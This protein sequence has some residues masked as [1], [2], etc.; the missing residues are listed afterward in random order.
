[1]STSPFRI[2]V[3]ICTMLLLSASSF[4]ADQ[5]SA[6]KPTETA[7]FAN[8]IH[9]RC[10]T[11]VNGRF[12]YFAI[13]TAEP[14]HTNR[15]LALMLGAELGDKYLSVLFDPLDTSGADFGCL[16]NDCRNI[17]ALVLMEHV[18]NRCELDN[19]QAGCAG[20]CAAN[21][22]NDPI[23]PG[24][25][26]ARD[27]MRCVDNCQRHPSNPL[28]EPVEPVVQCIPGSRNPKCN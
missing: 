9:V 15:M 7:V 5:L 27:D 10:E 22:N 26:S 14:R 17:K 8:R 20:F 4:A 12:A 18:P 19:T 24:F 13:S 28:C 6:C 25:C 21:G 23:C 3:A 11:P 2:A 1:M 16:V